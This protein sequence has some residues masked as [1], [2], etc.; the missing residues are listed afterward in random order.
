MET[1]EIS[2]IHSDH[3]LILTYKASYL[4][5]E[6]GKLKTWDDFTGGKEYLEAGL[7]LMVAASSS[8]RELFM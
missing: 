5:L 4:V 6:Q 3:R 7:F 1:S 8:G 2:I